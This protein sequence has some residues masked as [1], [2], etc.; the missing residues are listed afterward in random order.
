MS[1]IER[2]F[3]SLHDHHSHVSL[4]A[5][6]EGL[7]DVGGLEPKEAL[8]LLRGLPRDRLSLVKGWRTDRLSLGTGGSWAALEDMPPLVLVNAS[9]HGY[10]LSPA[11][12]PYIEALWPEFAREGSSPTS[13]ALWSERNLPRL[14]VFYGRVAGLDQ[15][16]LMAFMDS[17]ARLGVGSLEDMTL[18]GEEALELMSSP[19]F[20]GRIRAWATPEV[21]RELSPRA[22]ER[23]AGI[24]IF[25][26]GA[27]GARSA[28]LDAPFRG[29]GNGAL[30]RTDE[31]L[32]DLLG[33]LAGCG[34]SLSAHA[35]GHEAIAQLLRCLERLEA[36]GSRFPAVRIEHAQFISLEQAM[37]C[38]DLGVVLS[39]QPNFNSDSADY[40]DRL[41]SRHREENDP[42]RMLIDRARFV[43]GEDLVFGSDGMPHGPEYALAMS[44]FPAFEGQ[45][46][47]LD[48]FEAGYGSARGYTGQGS[49]FSIDEEAK[50]VRR[51]AYEGF[52]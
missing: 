27:L 10:A 18:C 34:K 13:G 12:L 17:M 24:K 44:L 35:I 6:F 9:L 2:R 26:D 4:Y 1:S 47:S 36:A 28:A 8:E 51:L 40:A 15:G 38:K 30:L 37:S 29:G 14:F 43:A 20:E 48:E 50:R 3:P 11:A 32:M 5:S 39:M 21:Y 16:K 42:F 46:L 52:L 41:I 33:E 49:L 23:C 25:L 31:A 22:R 7:P 19:P 45:R